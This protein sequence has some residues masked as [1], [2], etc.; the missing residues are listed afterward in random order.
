[1]VAQEGA[2]ALRGRVTSLRHVLG[3]RRLSDLEAE[4]EQLAMNMRRTPEPVF[5]THA[6]NQRPQTGIDLRS[7]AQGAGF[8]AP[9][10]AK[11]PTM[12]AHNGLGPDDRDGV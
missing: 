7:A 2:P 3:D 5:D 6:P 8:P 1:M 12:P 10:A 4:L 11:T 9:V